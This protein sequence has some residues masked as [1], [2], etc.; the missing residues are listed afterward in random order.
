MCS[1]DLID[2]STVD[3]DHES[4]L[5]A[6]SLSRKSKI[7]N[8]LKINHIIFRFSG[9]VRPETDR[10]DS[11][12]VTGDETAASEI[13]DQYLPRWRQAKKDWC[14]QRNKDDVE[15]YGDSLRVLREMHDSAQNHLINM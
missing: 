7:F 10:P 5:A 6:R 11:T 3:F 8:F 9:T 4:L 14:Q 12:T 1:S 13:L 15:K 2:R